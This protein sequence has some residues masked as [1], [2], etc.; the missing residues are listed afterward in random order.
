[1]TGEERFGIRFVSSATEGPPG[2]ERAAAEKKLKKVVD[3]QGELGYSA[4]SVATK[5]SR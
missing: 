3:G 5:K 4:K 2:R 1:M